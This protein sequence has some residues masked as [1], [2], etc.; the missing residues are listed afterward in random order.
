MKRFILDQSDEEFYS[1][2]SG[3]ALVGPLR[4]PL[5]PLGRALKEAVSLCHGISTRRSG[6]E[7]PR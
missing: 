3:L 1:S 5:Y 2:Q 4:E 6:Q 7:A